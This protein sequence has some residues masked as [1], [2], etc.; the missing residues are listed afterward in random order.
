MASGSEA[1]GRDAELAA[2]SGEKLVDLLR[3]TYRRS[4]FEAVA[5]VLKA[6]DRLQGPG[7]PGRAARGGVGG[8]AA[9]S[10]LEAA[11]A[12]R[13]QRPGIGEEG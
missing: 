7:A 5:R 6:R 4:D 8:C 1:D 9:V 12:R 11:E 3:T 2:L 13:D 10:A